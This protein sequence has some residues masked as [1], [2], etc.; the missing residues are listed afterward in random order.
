MQAEAETQKPVIAWSPS[1]KNADAQ[2][3]MPKDSVPKARSFLDVRRIERDLHVERRGFR[4]AVRPAEKKKR[5]F[6]IK[7]Q[8]RPLD[9]RFA[10][11]LIR[12]AEPASQDL[13]MSGG[14][15]VQAVLR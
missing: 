7:Q 5:L 2:N 1:F 9:L 3:G 12:P 8:R 15:P 13:W 10:H 11:R 14:A 4:I 6:P